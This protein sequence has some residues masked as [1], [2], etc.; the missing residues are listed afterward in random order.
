MTAWDA[1]PNDRMPLTRQGLLVAL[2]GWSLGLSAALG[3]CFAIVLHE[4]ELAVRI[5]HEGRP[6]AVQDGPD[7][8]RSSP[9]DPQATCIPRG[10]AVATRSP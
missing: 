4:N 5:L 1:H 3:A 10:H 8:A 9:A 7:C 2:A 6:A